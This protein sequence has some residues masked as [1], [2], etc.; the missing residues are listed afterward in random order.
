LHRKN[1]T[2]RRKI[3]T[4]RDLPKDFLEKIIQ[5]H[6]D[7]ELNF[8]DDVEFHPNTL[9]NMDGTGTGHLFKK[10]CLVIK[11]LL[12]LLPCNDS[13]CREHLSES[14]IVKENRIKCKECNDEFRVRENQFKSNNELTQLTESQSYLNEE[15]INLKHEIEISKLFEFYFQ[16]R[17]C[18]SNQS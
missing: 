2:L 16:I 9:V 5:F 6:Q 1:Y 18:Q 3:T 11:T 7:C 14:D 15:A 8:I 4:D 12:I 13:I 10:V 17:I